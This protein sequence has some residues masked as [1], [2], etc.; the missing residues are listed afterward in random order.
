MKGKALGNRENFDFATDR[1]PTA[2]TAVRR[3]F[4]EYQK[5]F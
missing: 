1:D 4:V 3:E 2:D 5:N